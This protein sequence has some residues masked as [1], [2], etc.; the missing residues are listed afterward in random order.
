MYRLLFLVA[1]SILF[2]SCGNPSTAN[3]TL[4]ESSSCIYH[5]VNPDNGNLKLYW[6]DSCGTPVQTFAKLRDHITNQGQ[7]LRFAMNGGMFLQDYSPQGLY[8]EKGKLIRKLNT[9]VND[10][11][12]F[13][14]EP[15]GIFYITKTYEASVC[16]SADYR[17]EDVDYAT[18]SGPMLLIDGAMHPKFRKGSSNLHYRNGVGILPDGNVLFAISKEKINFYDFATFFL[19][20]GCKNALYL[21][22]FVSR[23]YLPEQGV[24]QMDGNFGVMIAEVE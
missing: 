22:G 14:L 24:E 13:Y 11:G 18:Q 6:A 10:Y 9:K 23:L 5:T 7:K 1:T 3:T 19:S 17:S 21:D 4:K 12:N 2:F 20:K 16:T 8:V 15:N